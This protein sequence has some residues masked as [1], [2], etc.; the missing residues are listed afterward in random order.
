MVKDNI[1]SHTSGKDSFMNHYAWQTPSFYRKVRKQALST[2]AKYYKTAFFDGMVLSLLRV[3]NA[4]KICS[5]AAQ[6]RMK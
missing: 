1:L 3:L 4:Q 2:L 5:H 6:V